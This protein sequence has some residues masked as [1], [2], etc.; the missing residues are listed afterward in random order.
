MENETVNEETVK[1]ENKSAPTQTV[2]TDTT[3]K[4]IISAAE[5]NFQAKLEEAVVRI[6]LYAERFQGVGEH[7]NIVEEF[8]K[9]IEDYDHALGCLATINR[10]KM[11]YGM[12]NDAQAQ[13]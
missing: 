12:A 5:R 13:S 8:C 1:M 11:D 10:V 6:R 4:I 9:A 2:Q 3:G 7:P